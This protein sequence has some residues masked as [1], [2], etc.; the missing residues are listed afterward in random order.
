MKFKSQAILCSTIVIFF[1]ITAFSQS[2]YIYDL[3]ATA[4]CLKL[5]EKG[6][7]SLA[8]G[9]SFQ[10]SDSNFLGEANDG[11]PRQLYFYKHRINTSNFQLGYSLLPHLS[12]SLFHDRAKT[13]NN[14]ENTNLLNTIFHTS[15]LTGIGIGTYHSFKLGRK[16]ESTEENQS[17]KNRSVLIDL[18]GGYS[19]G[20]IEN[21]YFIY[22]AGNVSLNVQKVYLQSGIHFIGK[23]LDF[24]YMLKLGQ[25]NYLNGVI[26][27]KIDLADFQ[28]IASVTNVKQFML[29][30]NT[31]KAEVKF[32]KFGLFSQATTGGNQEFSPGQWFVGTI[33]VGLSVRLQA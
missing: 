13:S 15:H 9:T 30:E 29:W 16:S 20:Q 6:D 26:N 17:T 7:L 4:H 21:Q 12:I 25:I 1:S 22:D 28:T 24:S 3:P 23:H 2:P 33:H 14:N 19:R 27:G 11:R 5:K 18:H 8:M 32:K 10:N 31:L